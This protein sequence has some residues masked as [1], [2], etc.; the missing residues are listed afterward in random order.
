V[1]DIRL[2]PAIDSAER[3]AAALTRASPAISVGVAVE[4]GL[5]WSAA[6]G[7][8][9]FEAK[10][11]ATPATRFRIYSLSKGLTAA[12][13][14]ALVEQGQLDLDE[15]VARRFSGYPVLD[16]GITARQL[17][18][19]LSGI[20]HYRGREAISTQSCATPSDALPI[21]ARDPLQH[22]P[23][24]TYLYSSWGY[25]VLS[26]VLADAAGTTFESLVTRLVIEP[27]GMR[28]T[29]MAGAPPAIG[30]E[31]SFYE[32]AGTG[33]RPA[34]RVDNRCKWGAGGFVSTAEDLARFGGSLLEGRLIAKP[35]VDLLLTGMATSSGEQTGYAMGFGVSTDSSGIRRAVHSGS[36]IGGRSAIVML[37]DHRVV[38]VLLANVEGDRLTGAALQIADAFRLAAARLGTP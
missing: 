21:F 8:S 4:G 16:A 31:A 36:A 9:D 2:R 37:P 34:R 15:P 3:I 26:A 23:G 6:F 27:A 19:H 14:L 28:G 12:A 24:S 33:V 20:R 11:L 17:L 10:T 18:G 1:S 29:S 32:V 7:F 5:V 22:R 35:S 30:E 25:V 13:A 38:V